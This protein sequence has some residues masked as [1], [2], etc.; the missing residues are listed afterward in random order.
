MGLADKVRLMQE[1]ISAKN[2]TLV[3][4]DI[5]IGRVKEELE[6]HVQEIRYLS[7]NVLIAEKKYQNLVEKYHNQANQ[8]QNEKNK[9]KWELQCH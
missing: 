7:E 4:K 6:Q 1:D 9:W 5:I 3:E 8:W 2:R